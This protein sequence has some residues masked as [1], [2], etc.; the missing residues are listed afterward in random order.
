MTLSGF[1]TATFRLVEKRLY[2]LQY[3]VPS[4]QDDNNALEM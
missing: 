4:L 2:H 1:E 3:R